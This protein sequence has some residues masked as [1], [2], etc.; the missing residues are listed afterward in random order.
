[1]TAWMAADP[2][3]S[4]RQFVHNMVRDGGIKGVGGFSL[5]CGK[6]RRKTERVIEPLAIISNR[7]ECPDQVSWIASQR[8]ETVGLSNKCFGDSADR[9]PKIEEGKRLLRKTVMKSYEKGLSEDALVE[10]LLD[11]LDHDDLPCPDGMGFE[12]L[13]MQ[14]KK[15]IFIRP[16]GDEEHQRQMEE[17]RACAPPVFPGDDDLED[18]FHSPPPDEEARDS[19]MGFMTGMYG[20]QRQT[21]LL[22]DWDGNV[23]FTERALFDAWGRD[24][25]RGK[26]DLTYRFRIDGWD[27]C[28]DG[29]AR[30][31]AAAIKASGSILGSKLA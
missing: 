24:I 25:P 5:M 8:D 7:N 6:L 31:T 3:M 2:D 10:S 1:M 11:I 15:S 30:G 12:E 13:I 29:K 20:T 27:V 4:L 14:F 26:G 19:S 16:V 9:W 23:R 17:S 21:V 28:E 22:V 18:M